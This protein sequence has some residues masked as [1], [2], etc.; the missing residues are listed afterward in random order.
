MEFHEIANWFPLMDENGLAELAEDIRKNGQGLPIAVY[1][2]KILDGRNRY[3]ACLSVGV[4]PKFTSVTPDDPV[5]YVLSHNLHR[6]DLTPSQRAMIGDRARGWYDEK[7][8]EKYDATVGRPS[9]SVE[10]LPPITEKVKAR[11]QAGKAVGVSGR[12][13]DRAKRVREQGHTELVAAVEKGDMD[14][15]SAAVVASL[16]KDTQETLLEDANRNDWSQRQL[17]EEVKRLA[18]KQDLR[19]IQ[20][21]TANGLQYAKMAIVQ[22]EKISPKDKQREEALDLV[23]KWIEDHR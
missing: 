19:H 21:K 12:T 18:P 9:K 2:E 1:E 16:P 7:A 15:H 11:D 3:K 10:T 5:V 20:T 22:L 14:L 13:M 4:T 17:M 6:R 8:K 23:V